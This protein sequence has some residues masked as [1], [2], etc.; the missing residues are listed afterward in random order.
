M[1][2]YRQKSLQ[3]SA[4]CTVVKS[5]SEEWQCAELAFHCSETR[6]SHLPSQNFPPGSGCICSQYTSMSLQLRE[7]FRI[8]TH[9]I[10]Q[11]HPSLEAVC[12][13]VQRVP[14]E[15]LSAHFTCSRVS[16]C[17]Q[18]SALNAVSLQ[19]LHYVSLC[20]HWSPVRRH[21]FGLVCHGDT[22]WS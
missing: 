14:R 12:S 2:W 11:R 5:L 18:S 21:R 7:N 6:C 17:L 19:Y 4:K 20:F 8:V 1:F 13:D 22:E 15:P 9:L 3:A 10:L 16:Q